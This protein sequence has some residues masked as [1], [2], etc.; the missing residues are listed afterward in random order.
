MLS[1]DYYNMSYYVPTYTILLY[2][3]LPVAT[4]V[5]LNVQKIC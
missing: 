3:L 2:S 4:Y 1:V 5:Q